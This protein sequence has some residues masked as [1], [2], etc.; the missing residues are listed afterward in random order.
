MLALEDGG[1]QAQEPELGDVAHDHDVEQPVVER[2]SRGQPH[3]AAVG[4]GVCRRDRV[5]DG[6]AG[7]AAVE[8]D[9]ERRRLPGGQ[10]AQR[11]VGVDQVPADEAGLVGDPI[12]V[13]VKAAAGDSDEGSTAGFPEVERSHGATCEDL[14]GGAGVE[15]DAERAGEVVPPPAGQHSQGFGAKSS[16]M[17]LSLRAGRSNRCGLET[18]TWSPGLR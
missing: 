13:R 11:P 12:G 7:L 6:A 5:A 14:A 3:A 16:L 10:R 1:Q 4:L 2:S 17:G 18:A 8:P 15:W 9:R